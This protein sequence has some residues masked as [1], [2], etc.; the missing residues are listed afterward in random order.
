MSQA[1]KQF[2]LNRAASKSDFLSVAQAGEKQ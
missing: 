2:S 1:Q